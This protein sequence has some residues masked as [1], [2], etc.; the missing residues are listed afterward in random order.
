MFFFP[1]QSVYALHQLEDDQ[2]VKSLLSINKF[3]LFREGEVD[4]WSKEVYE[5]HVNFETVIWKENQVS[6]LSFNVAF[7]QG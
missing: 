3:Q 5:W 7:C 2:T 1:I 4:K 6:C